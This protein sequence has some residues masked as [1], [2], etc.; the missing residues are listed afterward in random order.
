MRFRKCWTPCWKQRHLFTVLCLVLVVVPV[1]P[2]PRTRH[3]FRRLDQSRHRGTLRCHA[4]DAS[5]TRTATPV[6]ENPSERPPAWNPLGAIVAPPVGGR[7]CADGCSVHGTCNRWTGE[8]ACPVHY[9][10]AA[11][12]NP[13][14]PSCQLQGG[15]LL[16]P[17]EWLGTPARQKALPLAR[18]KEESSAESSPTPPELVVMGTHPVPCACLQEVQRV[19]LLFSKFDEESI[20]FQKSPGPIGAVLC[21]ELPAGAGAWDDLLEGAGGAGLPPRWWLMPPVITNHSVLDLK[22][23]KG[24][25]EEYAPHQVVAPQ[26]LSDADAA[27]LL[28][29]A[30]RPGVHRPGFQPLNVSAV[31]LAPRR[32]CLAPRCG[33]AGWCA[34]LECAP[35]EEGAE[36]GG[37]GHECRCF[38]GA[39]YD[40]ADGCRW[41]APSHEGCPRECT[42]H[43]TC[44]GMGFCHCKEGYWGID[45]AL[46]LGS[47]ERPEVAPW[48]TREQ[49]FV[50]GSSASNTSWASVHPRIY[51]METPP[52]LRRGLD[53][54]KFLEQGFML[55]LLLGGH[56]VADPFLADYFY[57]PHSNLMEP[58]RTEA[59]LRWARETQPFWNATMA[60]GIPKIGARHLVVMLSEHGP[61][62]SL[63]HAWRVNPSKAGRQAGLPPRDLNAAA[64]DRPWSVLQVNGRHD[65]SLRPPC[66][67]GTNIHMCHVCFV[68]GTD[69]VLPVPPDGVEVPF[70]DSVQ[71]HQRWELEAMGLERASEYRP[72]LAV[73]Q[74]RMNDNRREAR[75]ALFNAFGCNHSDIWLLNPLSRSPSCMNKTLGIQS[76]AEH[77]VGM[78]PTYEIMRQSKFCLV[79]QGATQGDPRRHLPA[80]GYGCVPVMLLDGASYTLDEMIDWDRASVTIPHDDIPRLAEILRHKVETGE[81]EKLKANLEKIWPLLWWHP[82]ALEGLGDL[83]SFGPF[84]A[85]DRGERSRDEFKKSRDTQ[86]GVVTHEEGGAFGAVMDILRNRLID[87]GELPLTMRTTPIR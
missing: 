2:R 23:V 83:Y 15:R 85:C 21:V 51:V 58:P 36:E 33:G 7:P 81:Y 16:D 39:T 24:L 71:S 41:Q 84:K 40:A 69:I 61:G 44:D 53:F 14:L 74:G 4:E 22:Y 70:C 8:C 63:L 59:K 6:H 43:G 5:V 11:C 1:E 68:A 72:L 62:E 82:G 79:P 42:N 13:L 86:T 48:T 34:S 65:M 35:G 49:R 27:R 76:D 32:E 28:A 26:E 78:L 77:P 73:F 56:R 38:P 17:A 52:T 29:G 30:L 9:S 37:C 67:R 20:F 46:R 66:G 47:D 54:M 60:A 12:D 75:G 25:R 45:C 64:P 55:Q 10:G 87:N 57:L 80:I 18:R 31:R 3:R 50:R 19:P